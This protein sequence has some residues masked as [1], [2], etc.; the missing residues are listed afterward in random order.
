MFNFLKKLFS[1]YELHIP[2]GLIDDKYGCIEIKKNKLSNEEK[3]YDEIFY[4]HEFPTPFPRNN[5][6]PSQLEAADNINTSQVEVYDQKT[7]KKTMM[8]ANQV[9]QM[10]EKIPDGVNVPGVG[11]VGGKPKN[12]STGTASSSATAATT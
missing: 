5:E 3:I 10:Q 4:V 6:M 7:G 9:A 8:D 2:D 11:K 1:I 12:S